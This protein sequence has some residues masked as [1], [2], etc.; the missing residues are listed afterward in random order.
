MV[1]PKRSA[2]AVKR[3]Q[4]IQ[5][6]IANHQSATTQ[7]EHEKSDR[8]KHYDQRIKNEQDQIKQLSKQIEELKR[9]I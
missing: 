3:I 1:D 5:Q 2:E 8:I 6:M 4:T 9:Q 7:I